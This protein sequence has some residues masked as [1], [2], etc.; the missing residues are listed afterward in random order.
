[1]NI[2]LQRGTYGMTICQN[3]KNKHKVAIPLEFIYKIPSNN[4]KIS[5]TLV[6]LI[7]H[8]GESLHFGHYVSEFFDT[9]TGIWWKC[10][11]DGITKI[12]DLP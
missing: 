2:L 1:M 4:E 10:D 6:S 5:Y 12:G 3:I 8:Y 11:D 9:N 7:I